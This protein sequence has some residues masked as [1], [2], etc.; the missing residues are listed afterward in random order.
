MVWAE[1]VL[2][3]SEEVLVLS[4]SDAIALYILDF[5]GLMH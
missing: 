4:W 2:Q 1:C 3:Y 5:L